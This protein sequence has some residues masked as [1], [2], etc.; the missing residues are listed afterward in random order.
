VCRRSWVVAGLV[1]AL[2][3]PV[4]ITTDGCALLAWL[5][6]RDERGVRSLRGLL[7]AEQKLLAL[8]MLEE[9]PVDLAGLAA[10]GERLRVG[11]R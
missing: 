2:S 9:E 4:E 7:P 8:P 1:P 11:L 6:A 3:P 5:G 10:I